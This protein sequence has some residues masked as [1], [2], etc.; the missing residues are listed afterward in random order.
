MYHR[1]CLKCVV[2][3]R[4]LDSVS[5]LEHDGEPYCSNCHRTHLGQG[6]DS[7]GT[8]VPVKPQHDPSTKSRSFKAVSDTDLHG[9]RPL[10]MAPS[11]SQEPL[12]VPASVS[13]Q[14]GSSIFPTPASTAGTPACAR[15]HTPV[16]FAEQRLAVGRK[17]HRACLRCEGC[18]ATLDTNRVEEGPMDLWDQGCI[19]TWCHMCYSKKFGPRGI[20][21][22]GMSYPTGS[23]RA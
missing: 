11:G 3:Q 14:S 18:R 7:F 13:G 23:G 5:L 6:K 1:H 16:Y 20:G 19:N 12:T 9:R 2:C 15:C 22:A 8:A 4:R 10:P 21:V 17:W